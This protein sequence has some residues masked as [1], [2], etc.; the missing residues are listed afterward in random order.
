M[1]ISVNNLYQNGNSC[2][3]LYKAHNCSYW[4]VPWEDADGVSG[5]VAIMSRKIVRILDKSGE[6]NA[7]T[8]R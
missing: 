5:Y 3:L 6:H 4:D 7:I 8:S 2:D 1:T